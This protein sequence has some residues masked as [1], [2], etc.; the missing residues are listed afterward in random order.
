MKFEHLFSDIHVKNVSLTNR[1]V[2]APMTRIS[3]FDNGHANEKMRRYYERFAKGGF[4]TIITEGIYTDEKYSQGY[5]NQP[6]LANDEQMKTWE[7]VVETVHQEGA[8]LIAQLMHAGGQSQGNAYTEDTI[9]PSENA[10]KGEQLG[11]YGGSGPFQTPKKMTEEDIKQVKESF[12]Q[13]AQRAKSAGF[14]GVELHGA[15]GY[16]LDQFLTDYLNDREDQYGGS[17]ENRLR[18]FIE[19]IQDVRKA[20]GEEFMIGIRMSQIKVSD[21]EHKWAEG[22]DEAEYIF[23]T[24]GKSSLDYIHVTD[25]DGSAPSFGKDS[26]TLAQ[27]A[28]DFSGLPVIANGKLGDPVRAEKV[29]EGKQADLVSLATSALAN[30]DLP[31]KV[32]LGQDLNEFDFESTLLPQADIKDHELQMELVK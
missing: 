2:V 24:L 18:L 22:E 19:V 15:N 5:Y 3:A 6:G 29:L 30:P 27:A 28:K 31:N 4:S 9:A 14:D 20:V 17:V 26:R 10:P 21:P 16:L 1:F 13:S 23:S 25:G 11:F 7:P 8:H 12:V 32:Q